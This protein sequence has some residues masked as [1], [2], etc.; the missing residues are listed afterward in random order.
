MVHSGLVVPSSRQSRRSAAS[1]SMTGFIQRSSPPSLSDGVLKWTPPVL[2]H[3]QLRQ[4]ELELVIYCK[5]IESTPLLSSCQIF[6]FLP[7]ALWPP[8]A[9]EPGVYTGRGVAQPPVT[10]QH[11]YGV[12][13]EYTVYTVYTTISCLWCSLWKDILDWPSPPSSSLH[14][15]PFSSVF[16]RAGH[17]LEI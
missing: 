5:T 8:A 12:H 9:L 15:T 4:V 13:I 7:L 17:E 2:W 11:V 1:I 10:Q 14:S 6:I 16:I 3:F